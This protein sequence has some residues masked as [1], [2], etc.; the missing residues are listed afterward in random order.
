MVSRNC[1]NLS[2]KLNEYFVCCCTE[3]SNTLPCWLVMFLHD[4]VLANYELH[5]VSDET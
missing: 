1:N 5:K 3:E 2:C 4:A